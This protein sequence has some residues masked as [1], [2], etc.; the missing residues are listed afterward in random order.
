MNPDKLS[1][2]PERG[3]RRAPE[4]VG[5]LRRGPCPAARR[6]APA[7]GVLGGDL[8]MALALA[9]C[10]GDVRVRVAGRRGWTRR[11]QAGAP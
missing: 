1:P 9:L 5:D 10:G 8:A 6:G 7:G 3:R 4:N 11:S 2:R